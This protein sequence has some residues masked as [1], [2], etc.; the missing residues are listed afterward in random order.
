MYSF[1]SIDFVALITALSFVWLV[2]HGKRLPIRRTI[3][4]VVLG[5]VGRSPRMMYHAQSLAENH[6]STYLIGYSGSTLIKALRELP[7]LTMLPLTPPPRFIGSLPRQLFILA[8]PVKLAIQAISLLWTLL[9]R[10]PT[11]EYILVQNPPSI[12]TLVLVQL[13]CWLRGCKLIIDWH[14]LG[15]SILALRLGEKHRLVKLAK[16]IERTFGK[17]AFLH[18]F[19][20][21]AM[22]KKLVQ[23][24]NLEGQTLTLHDRPP[25]HFRRSTPVETH[26]LFNRLHSSLSPSI[27]SFLPPSHPPSTSPFTKT[28]SS[29]SIMSGFDPVFPVTSGIM[30]REDRPALVVS[31]TSWTPDEDFSLFLEMLKKYELRAKAGGLPKLLALITGK[32]P[33]RDHYMQK[34]A[35]LE[36]ADKWEWVRCISV[37]LEPE[38]YP[39]LLGSADLGVSLHSSSSGLDLPMKVVDMFGCSLPVCALDFECL[40]EL[41]KDGVNGLAFKTAD[42]LTDQVTK[43]ISDFP[44]T[45]QLDILRQALQKR[46]RISTP[47]SLSEDDRSQWN[48]WT[49]NWN[50]FVR[51]VLLH[52]LTHTTR[53]ALN[54]LSERNNS[55]K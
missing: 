27:R 41:V 42:E 11:P 32:G 52:D 3:A 34:V 15:Y 23:E 16:R 2:F 18:L 30:L 1:S 12:P 10:M 7:N 19:V 54:T 37:W 14:N 49:D 46:T 29:T 43:L 47:S 6:F 17:R 28:V 38:D 21:D 31:S 26:D 53:H 22:K 5:D 4:V 51:P 50:A 25:S 36:R 48:D 9:F 8:A 39:V 40:D 45:N 44:D 13:V 20:T 35:Q 55:S 24:W 33:L